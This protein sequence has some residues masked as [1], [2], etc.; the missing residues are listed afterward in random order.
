VENI[1]I[2]K[3]QNVSVTKVESEN[4]IDQFLINGALSQIYAEEK[5]VNRTVNYVYW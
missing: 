4:Y 2:T 1:I 3:T 5:M